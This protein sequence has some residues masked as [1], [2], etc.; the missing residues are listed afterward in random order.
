MGADKFREDVETVLGK[1]RHELD[2]EEYSKMLALK[3]KL[4][5][6]NSQNLVKINHSVMELVSAK[7]LIQNGF[8]VELEHYLDEVSCDIYAVKG[9]GSVI[10]EVET[11]FVPPEHAVDPLIYLRARI[12]S[13]ITR[14]SG[15][16]NK[17]ML[18]TPPYYIMEIPSAL[19]KPPRFR[20]E[21]EVSVIK[22]LCDLYYTNPP[23]SV[24]EIRNARIHSIL[25]VDVDS[26]SVREWEVNEYLGKAALWGV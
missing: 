15:F 16:A 5:E 19:T 18:A 4:L 22:G 17:F 1:M 21:D 12:A 24:E 25:A 23:V 11:G 3:E 13:K 2:E 8:D 14:Y 26:A 7:H 10:V 6:L 9:Y 20:K